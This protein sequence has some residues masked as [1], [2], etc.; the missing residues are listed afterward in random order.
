MAHSLLDPRLLAP[1]SANE[2]LFNFAIR[3]GLQLE[4]FKA[5]EIKR[6]LRILDKEVL[7]AL[8]NQLDTR[9][10]LIKA[11]G[12]IDPGPL[13]TKRLEELIATTN[14]IIRGG[15]TKMG[16]SMTKSMKGFALSEAQWQHAMLGRSTILN[17]S[18]NMPSLQALNSAITSKPMQGRFLKQWFEQLS[19]NAQGRAEAAIRTGV[20]NGETIQAIRNRLMT[21]VGAS[22]RE[23]TIITRTAVSHVS[24]RAREATY[25]ANEDTIKGVRWVSTLDSRTSFIC[26][27]LDGRVFPVGEGE[28]PPAHHQCRSTTVPVLKSWKDLGIDLKEAPP[29]TR[30]SMNGQVPAKQ[31]YGQWLKKQG[32]ATQNKALGPA[33]AEMF[34]NGELQITDL[35]DQQGKTLRLDQLVVTDSGVPNALN[36]KDDIVEAFALLKTTNIADIAKNDPLH[37]VAQTVRNISIKLAAGKVPT[38][39]QLVWFNTLSEG[40]QDY[41]RERALDLKDPFKKASLFAKKK[42]K[43]GPPPKVG[44]LPAPT[45]HVPFEKTPPPIERRLPPKPKPKLQIPEL[46][47]L[48][49]DSMTFV[50]DL[51]G[52]TG[53]KLY[54]DKHGVSWVIKGNTEALVRN[55]VLAN[56]LYKS[57][58]VDVPDV[59]LAM[60]NGELRVASRFRG[61]ETAN[62]SNAAVLS[63]AQADFATDAWLANWDVVGL[64]FDNLKQ[65]SGTTN[66]IRL[67]QGGALAFRAQGSPKGVLFGNVVDE[68]DSLRDVSINPQSAKVFGSMSDIQLA[69][70]IDDLIENVDHLL[71]DKLIDQYG[72]IDVLQRTALKAKM[73]RRLED[74]AERSKKFKNPA[75]TP[76]RGKTTRFTSNADWRRSLTVEEEAAFFQWKRNPGSIREVQR[77]LYNDATAKRHGLAIERRLLDGPPVDKT[78]HRGYGNM[79]GEFVDK[80]VVGETFEIEAT[81]GFSTK[82]STASNFGG[83]S[84]SRTDS[85][86]VVLRIKKSQA[87]VDI[88]QIDSYK[89]E[90]EVLIPKGTRFKVISK[91]WVPRPNAAF[92]GNWE[93]ILEEVIDKGRVGDKIAARGT[94]GR[95]STFAKIDLANT[96]DEIVKII[97]KANKGLRHIE[98]ELADMSLEAS[99]ELGK[100][101][102]Q[103]SR[104]KTAATVGQRLKAVRMIDLPD[105]VYARVISEPGGRS[106]VLVFNNKYF[107]TANIEKY[108]KAKLRDMDSGWSIKTDNPIAQMIQ[109]E[110]GHVVHRLG[111]DLIDGIVDYIDTF[112]PTLQDLPSRYAMTKP[113]EALAEAFSSV[114]GKPKSF[115]TPWERKFAEILEASFAD[116]GLTSPFGKFK[117]TKVDLG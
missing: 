57:V 117:V 86:S 116:E 51:P 25:L 104:L 92:R 2:E 36:T 101:M 87:G 54:V 85:T 113:S 43:I 33:R 4:Q 114:L 29:G 26:Q 19:K 39:K 88:T 83:S 14:G 8:L 47:V 38:P 22:K 46:E 63:E 84:A 58:G 6:M 81:S 103:L 40:A 65:A 12:G 73:R 100:Q 77:G 115:W 52:S 68:I 59:R 97:K 34:R 67:D 105:K 9:K 91:E 93:I 95:A 1:T 10:A 69:K 5:G 66:L 90:A 74:L 82:K 49:V 102:V 111:D 24:S 15:V 75:P 37:D 11:A 7:P 110:F 107:S 106:G 98:F 112:P 18:F 30:A 80:F 41:I 44:G 28:R 99:K 64:Q 62:F 3:R 94:A 71:M 55:E 109:H 45:K 32:K 56:K 60:H 78:I 53:P 108:K 13:V 72:P 21:A 17:I 48:D 31:T 89:S 70:S 76:V 61:V 50:R 35:V 20:T 16:K 96:A 27:S 79:P 23:A 42:P